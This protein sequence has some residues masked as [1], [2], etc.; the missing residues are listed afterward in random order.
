[1]TFAGRDSRPAPSP[2][3]PARTAGRRVRRGTEPQCI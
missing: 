2:A 1:V 3:V